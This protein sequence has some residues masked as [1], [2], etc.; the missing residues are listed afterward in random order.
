M[1]HYNLDV[2][3]SRLRYVFAGSVR[4]LATVRDNA[5]GCAQREIQ[6]R[7]CCSSEPVPGAVRVGQAP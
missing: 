6:G 3:V 2:R 1:E 7:R 5:L 4:S